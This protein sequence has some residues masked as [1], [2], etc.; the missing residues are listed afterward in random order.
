MSSWVARVAGTRCAGWAPARSGPPAALG[1]L[2]LLLALVPVRSAGAQEPGNAEETDPAG[3]VDPADE[4]VERLF[5]ARVGAPG[6]RLQVS[7]LRGADVF[8]ATSDD[9]GRLIFE[10]RVADSDEVRFV[11][12]SDSWQLDWVAKIRNARLDPDIPLELD[13]GAFLQRAAPAPASSSPKQPAAP[14]VDDPLPCEGGAEIQCLLRLKRRLSEARERGDCRAALKLAQQLLDDLPEFAASDPAAVE[15][16]SLH[17]ECAHLGS[18]QRDPPDPDQIRREL[19]LRRAIAL[20][21]GES[22][23]G[24]CHPQ[25]S[26]I[27]AAA[28][29]EL[30]ETAS[31]AASARRARELCPAQPAPVEWEFYFRLGLGQLDRAAEVA[32]EAE[33]DLAAFLVAW[34][35]YAGGEC[36]DVSRWLPAAGAADLAEPH[37][38]PC[39]VLPE[40]TCA[41]ALTAWIL[42]CS[43]DDQLAA[44]AGFLRSNLGSE[45]R[46]ASSWRLEDLA[47][48]EMARGRWDTAADLFGRLLAG[49]DTAASSSRLGAWACRRGDAL[50]RAGRPAGALEAFEEASRHWQG[51]RLSASDLD[52]LVVENNALV[53]AAEVRGTV[54]ESR[55]G[56][57][58]ERLDELLKAAT[59]DDASEEPLEEPLRPWRL[60]VENNL[61]ELRTRA[62]AEHAEVD[63]TEAR[64]ALERLA[65]LDANYRQH[66]RSLFEVGGEVSGENAGEADLPR[67]CSRLAFAGDFAAAADEVE[68]GVVSEQQ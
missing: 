42:S 24:W 21:A 50:L 6:V 26:R 44:Y 15:L 7:S 67:A 66:V 14:R 51:T 28:H 39:T 12:A 65:A 35:T 3:H 1:A 63:P 18:I 27:L 32:A 59:G 30:R 11:S 17:Y 53:L 5:V 34:S 13:V 40:S 52:R 33:G 38:T 45:E 29:S 25:R 64:A 10:L 57:V 60:A 56:A 37:A 4:F 31:A 68:D 2:V 55:S 48:V 23:A 62:E 20:A 58:S 9:D 41:R 46:G 54:D 36:P 49:S 47:E 43:N 8:V 19:L 22:G 16:A 61:L